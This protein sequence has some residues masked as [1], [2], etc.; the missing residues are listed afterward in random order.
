MLAAR[1]HFHLAHFHLSDCFPASE[2]LH[3]GG[4]HL[5]GEQVLRVWNA[6]SKRSDVMVV[7]RVS[8]AAG[9]T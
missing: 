9:W 1:P 8:V 5:L 2:C 6:A 4:R 3:R 7:G